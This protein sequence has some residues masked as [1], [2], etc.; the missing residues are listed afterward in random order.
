MG[1]PVAYRQCSRPV[2]PEPPTAH[3]TSSPSSERSPVHASV[4]SAWALCLFLSAMPSQ[5]CSCLFNST[6][7]APY[8]AAPPTKPS[9]MLSLI[10]PRLSAAPSYAPSYTPSHPLHCLHR[11]CYA[12]SCAASNSLSLSLSLSLSRDPLCSFLPMLPLSFS[13]PSPTLPAQA[14]LCSF[15]CSR[16]FLLPKLPL[17]PLSILS[18]SLSPSPPLL[19]M[20]PL[21]PL[22]SS[23]LLPMLPLDPL[24]LPLSFLCS[25]SSLHPLCPSRSSQHPPMLLPMLPP[26]PLSLSLPPSLSLCSVPRRLL[27]SS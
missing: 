24:S 14:L 22:S 27:E 7:C 6:S 2:R 18:P 1:E 10:L 8:Q 17:D 26:L 15:Q 13:S 12:P 5:L 23:G 11:P 21:D 9:A 19:P 4:L 16:S 3:A 25:L 20:L